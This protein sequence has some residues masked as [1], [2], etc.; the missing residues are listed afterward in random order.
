M[1][2]VKKS[3]KIKANLQ[4]EKLFYKPYP[5]NVFSEDLAFLSIGSVALKCNT[6][7]TNDSVYYIRL[8]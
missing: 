4:R 2:F 8:K 6:A 3:I 7:L 5:V 1:Q